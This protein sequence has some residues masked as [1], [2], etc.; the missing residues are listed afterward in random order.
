MEHVCPLNQNEPSISNTV[1]FSDESIGKLKSIMYEH[2]IPKGT[3]I[4]WEGDRADKLYFLKEGSVKLM[5]SADDGKDLVLYYFRP[6]D[7]FGE[8]ESFSNEVCG[9]TAE[10]LT[11][12]TIGII[13]QSDLEVLLWQHGDLAIEFMKWMG[14]MHRFTQLKLRDLLFYGKSGALASTLVR[15]TNSY[16]YEKDGAIHFSVAFTNYDLADLIGA[17]RETVNRML[18]HMKKEGIIDY[19]NGSIIIKDIEYIKSICHCDDCPKEVCRL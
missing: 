3:N 8:T 11:E 18:N 9:F 2:H 7:I 4:F 17:T 6:G 10:A 16:G 15:M 12:C 19:H 13:Q 5:K 1:S 14:F